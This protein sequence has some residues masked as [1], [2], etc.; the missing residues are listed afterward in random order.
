MTV[1]QE[2]LAVGAAAPMEF[3]SHLAAVL[4]E[5]AQA[6]RATDRGN[7]A[8]LEVLGA[9]VEHTGNF[10]QRIRAIFL[11]MP[12]SVYEPGPHQ[13]HVLVH[14]WSRGRQQ[15][16]GEMLNELTAAAVEDLVARLH[17]TIEEVLRERT[18]GEQLAQD[19]ERS[20][21]A[22]AAVEGQYAEATQRADELA[23][24]LREADATITFLREQLAALS[25]AAEDAED[26]EFAE[27]EAAA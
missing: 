4:R 2:N 7:A 3:P 8:A 18:A 12:E 25:I 26:E 10:D 19:V 24:R 23:H 9:F 27:E 16:P 14:L 5:R 22:V 15:R 21:A 6:A 1:Q 13:R 11:T 20:Q 17:A